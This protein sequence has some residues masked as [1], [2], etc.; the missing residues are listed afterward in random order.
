MEKSLQRFDA[1]GTTTGAREALR[2]RERWK[3]TYGF[4]VGRCVCAGGVAFSGARRARM[5]VYVGERTADSAKTRQSGRGV[6]S[7]VRTDANE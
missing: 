7:K 6:P 5:V 2:L 4:T 3:G 1:L